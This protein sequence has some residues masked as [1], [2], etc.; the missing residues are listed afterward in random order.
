MLLRLLDFALTAF[1]VWL[2]GSQVIRGWQARRTAANQGPVASAPDGVDSRVE[3]SMTLVPCGACGV[4]VPQA[5]TLPGPAG[6][7]FCSEACRAAGARPS[8]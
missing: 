4:H 2:V 7:I 6:N 8:S 5:R 3:R 1:L